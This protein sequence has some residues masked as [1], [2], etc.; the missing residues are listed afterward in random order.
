M[1]VVG[2]RGEGKKYTNTAC[3]FTT[4]SH[5]NTNNNNDLAVCD[6]GGQ[7]AFSGDPKLRDFGEIHF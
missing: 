1:Q 6:G 2:A 5:D 3:G 4:V 7:N